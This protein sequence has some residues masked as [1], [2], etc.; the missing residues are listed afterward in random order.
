MFIYEQMKLPI[1][2]MV[3]SHLELSTLPGSSYP[4][5]QEKGPPSLS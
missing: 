1:Q 3:Q 5:I 4:G 2:A